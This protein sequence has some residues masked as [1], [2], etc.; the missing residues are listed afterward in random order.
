VD[1]EPRWRATDG[2]PLHYPAGTLE[3]DEIADRVR[4]HLCGRWF[5]SL[6]AHA[7][8]GHQMSAVEYRALIG[9]HPRRS[10][11]R[12]G[13]QARK[14]AKMRER[15]QTDPGVIE[16]AKRGEALGRSG[17]LQA[18][19]LDVHYER[20]HSLA[21]IEQLQQH[22]SAL[23]HATAA[24]HRAHR[25]ARPWALG[26]P[27]LEAYLRSVYATQSAKMSE[28]ARA[29]GASYPAIHADLDR[30]GIPVK[31]HRERRV[32]RWS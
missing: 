24:R 16:G 1:V 14:A 30:L 13:L 31:H 18:R 5:R 3:V 23:G 11:D 7:A 15:R 12:P 26:S 21:R 19:A 25:K 29:L 32:W 4:C 20:G 9:L 2:T 28:I 17:E 8:H 22:D 10:L 27:D 6:G